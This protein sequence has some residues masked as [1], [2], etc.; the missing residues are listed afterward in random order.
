MVR[1]MKY[2]QFNSIV[3]VKGRFALFNALHQ[4]VIFL[5]TALYESLVPLI[6]KIDVL[7]D[8]HPTF[9]AYLIEQGYVIN[10]D[11]DEIDVVKHLSKSVDQNLSSFLLTINPNMMCN[12][13]CYYCYETHVKHSRINKDIAG[14]IKL[15]ISRIVSNDRLKYFSLSFFGG[16]PLLYFEKDVIPITDHYVAEC[17]AK[18]LVPFISFTTNGYLVDRDFIDYFV[19][20]NL[21]CSLQITLDGSKAE[22]DLVRFGKLGKGSYD[23]IIKNVLLLVTS[24]FFVRVRVNYT[25]KNLIGIQQITEDLADLADD[26]KRNFLIFDFHR[27]WQNDRKDDTDKVLN[28]KIEHFRHLGFKV[29]SKYLPDNVRNSC[30]A[31]KLNGVAIN[32]NGDIYKC[33]ARDFTPSTRAGFIDGNGELSWNDGYLQRRM[34]AKFNN[35]PCLKC[36]ILP[37]CNGGCS[38]HALEHLN[39]KEY[40][41]YFGDE[42]E[43]DKVIASKIED[44]LEQNK[45]LPLQA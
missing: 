23:T 26:K 41:V 4:K 21:R 14:R 15:L 22:H 43:K 36:R 35:A 45:R 29:A 34:N 38:Q 10:N 28:K 42:S 44:I 20:L 3:P 30:Y 11:V 12:F 27:V 17:R 7:R 6:D 37:I 24:G 8:I 13:G 16:E 39:G 32:Y 19:K 31:D 2:S 18:A 33:T 40:C 25:D 1:P 9:Y 5:E